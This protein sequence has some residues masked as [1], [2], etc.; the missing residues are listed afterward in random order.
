MY[1]MPYSSANDLPLSLLMTR[2]SDRS[3]LLPIN[4]ISILEV[5]STYRINNTQNV[6]IFLLIEIE[7]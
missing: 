2:E 7:I 5:S 4:I 1:L 3:H 6:N